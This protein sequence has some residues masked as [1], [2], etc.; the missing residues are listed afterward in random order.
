MPGSPASST[1]RTGH[2]SSAENPVEAVEAGR[3]TGRGSRRRFGHRHR[4]SA[5]ARCWATLLLLAR[6]GRLFGISNS[7][8]RSPG[9]GRAICPIRGRRRCRR[10][11]SRPSASSVERAAGK[12]EAVLHV[13][14]VP[15]DAGA[16]EDRGLFRDQRIVP[17]RGHEDVGADEVPALELQVYALVELAAK[18]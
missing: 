10:R 9:T 6:R 2:Q 16:E 17:A 4:L 13:V 1:Q 5:T 11:W 8:R 7:T 15:V 14:V 12:P 3:E 18:S